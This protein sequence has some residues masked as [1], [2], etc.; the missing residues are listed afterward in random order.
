MRRSLNGTM[1]V[2]WLSYVDLR[3]NSSVTVV[4]FPWCVNGTEQPLISLT[5]LIIII[6]P[7]FPEISLALSH[8]TNNY[9]FIGINS[10]SGLLK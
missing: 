2:F 9:I 6:A 5:A 3:V 8:S 4:F 7:S 1:E 10:S